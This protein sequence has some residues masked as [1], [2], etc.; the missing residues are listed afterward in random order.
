[1]VAPLEVEI[2]TAK[3][4]AQGNNAKRVRKQEDA[5]RTLTLSGTVQKHAKSGTCVHEY[6]IMPF[7]KFLWK[8]FRLFYD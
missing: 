5:R 7:D 8:F 1:M 2:E 6:R 3:I 4:E